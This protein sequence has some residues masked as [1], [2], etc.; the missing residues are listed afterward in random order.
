[1]ILTLVNGVMHPHQLQYTSAPC[2]VIYACIIP[3]YPDSELTE[4]VTGT[5]GETHIGTSTL[6]PVKTE[7]ALTCMNRTK[8]VR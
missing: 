6:V 4:K 7:P 3:M 8:R 5:V 1:M 2:D